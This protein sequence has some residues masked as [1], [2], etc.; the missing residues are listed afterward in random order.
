MV[1]LT[2]IAV[3][4]ALPCATRAARAQVL[5]LQ[6]VLAP[7]HVPAPQ[8]TALF[9]PGTSP[10]IPEPPF[11]VLGVIRQTMQHAGWI[12]Q[13]DLWFR[14]EPFSTGWFIEA[15]SN[16]RDHGLAVS[17]IRQLSDRID[18]TGWR[19]V[20]RA[21][22]KPG[23]RNATGEAGLLPVRSIRGLVEHGWRQGNSHIAA[24]AGL[25]REAQE[26]LGRSIRTVP[27]RLGGVLGAH[28]WLG[29]PEPGPFRVSHV[30]IYGE[31]DQTLATVTVIHRL[32]V[33]L[34][35]SR[36]SLGPEIQ[37]AGGPARRR[38]NRI[39]RPAFRE[40]RLGLGL[41]GIAFVDWQLGFNL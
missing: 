13:Q 38:G 17:H 40:W 18:G 8:S 15:R 27:W 11:G 14:P 32:G 1:V 30:Q 9:E 21:I 25:S 37:F 19:L 4:L 24:F 10:A 3:C 20:I 7:Q 5:A 39:Y 23:L 16:R 36:M 26:G 33:R 29:W 34:G 35:H 41:G 12:R 31:F 28:A 2:S 22:A 6:Q